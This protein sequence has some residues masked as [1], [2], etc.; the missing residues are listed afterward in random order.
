M[1]TIF[2]GHSGL[3]SLL[4]VPHP[5][6]KQ[7]LQLTAMEK[8]EGHTGDNVSGLAHMG[9]YSDMGFKLMGVALLT[10]W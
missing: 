2:Q 4:G 8:G 5:H 3:H 1:S 9:K 6:V 7:D 10:P